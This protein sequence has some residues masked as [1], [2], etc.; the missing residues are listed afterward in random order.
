[1]PTSTKHGR[2]LGKVIAKQRRDFPINCE[3]TGTAVVNEDVQRFEAV[4]C[5]LVTSSEASVNPSAR[6]ALIVALASAHLLTLSARVL[7][8]Y[9]NPCTPLQHFL[10]R[11]IAAES[12]TIEH[13]LASLAKLVAGA[14]VVDEQVWE[15]ELLQAG[16]REGQ[17]LALEDAAPSFL[18][19]S[20]A[21]NGTA[22]EDK[23]VLLEAVRFLAGALDFRILP[24]MAGWLPHWAHKAGESF[25]RCFSG[26]MS[27]NT[28]VNRS[29]AG[30]LYRHGWGGYHPA[31][32]AKLDAHRQILSIVDL[33]R[34]VQLTDRDLLS[35]AVGSEIDDAVSH[36]EETE[37]LDRVISLRVRALGLVAQSHFLRGRW[38]R[39]TPS[40]SAGLEVFW[41]AAR[42][43]ARVGAATA[44]SGRDLECRQAAQKVYEFAASVED[45]LRGTYGHVTDAVE[46]AALCEELASEA[47]AMHKVAAAGAR[48]KNI[49]R[50]PDVAVLQEAVREAAEIV[51]SLHAGTNLENVK[52][53]ISEYWLRL[54]RVQAFT[55]NCL[56]LFLQ[57]H[58][59]DF[60]CKHAP[61]LDWASPQKDCTPLS[62]AAES[63]GGVAPI[64]LLLR[65]YPVGEGGA[66]AEWDHRDTIVEIVNFLERDHD[67]ACEEVVR[68]VCARMKAGL[69]NMNGIIQSNQPRDRAGC[70]LK[71]SEDGAPWVCYPV[72]QCN[73]H[74]ALR[75]KSGSSDPPPVHRPPPS[76]HGTAREKLLRFY[77]VHLSWIADSESAPEL[78][79]EKKKRRVVGSDEESLGGGGG[80]PVPVADEELFADSV[81]ARNVPKIFTDKV[82]CVVSPSLRDT[83]GCAVGRLTARSQLG[84]HDSGCTKTFTTA[85]P[86]LRCKKSANVEALAT[87][88]PA[89][90]RARNVR[91]GVS[92][93][94]CKKAAVPSQQCEV[95]V[96]GSKHLCRKS[97]LALDPDAFVGHLKIVAAS[98]QPRASALPPVFASIHVEIGNPTVVFLQPRNCTEYFR[99]APP[100]R[101]FTLAIPMDGKNATL[102]KSLATLT[103]HLALKTVASSL[104]G[105]TSYRVGLCSGRRLGG[106]EEGSVV[107]SSSCAARA[108]DARSWYAW[109]DTKEYV[110]AVASDAKDI[111][112]RNIVILAHRMDRIGLAFAAAAGTSLLVKLESSSGACV[113]RPFVVGLVADARSGVVSGMDPSAVARVMGYIRETM[114]SYEEDSAGG[115]GGEEASAGDVQGEDDGE[116]LLHNLHML[117]A[118][119]AA[120][121]SDATLLAL[122]TP[123]AQR[124][125]SKGADAAQEPYW[126]SSF[127][128]SLD[129]EIDERQVIAAEYATK[130]PPSQGRLHLDTVV[131]P[132]LHSDRVS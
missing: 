31:S 1:M 36:A 54:R 44:P 70:A 53:V 8:G 2:L 63:S 119:V 102:V 60:D 51:V 118:L 122:L 3:G 82:A 100:G 40:M 49:W 120:A 12:A 10:S 103:L 74:R 92:G 52:K 95:E 85:N 107:A 15:D 33:L 121:S 17:E 96:A 117:A 94:L 80:D 99:A 76:H 127:A 78:L 68:N 35:V 62:A 84:A 38:Q 73:G 77:N 64:P 69:E 45:A 39:V 6:V 130:P 124:L 88:L 86:V 48:E 110:P 66:S 24:D 57:D 58:Q 67:S 111:D 71:V 128:S 81:I 50:K 5:P 4:H 47:L 101:C 11:P 41:F 75:R 59:Y 61:V 13:H 42:E 105:L 18:R 115:A 113:L 97:S 116:E 91:C 79:E 9:L 20:R 83:K 104:A 125:L 23:R 90:S 72:V 37:S 131:Y 56:L 55:R 129:E 87:A 132:P 106:E 43:R 98:K 65:D 46:D 114:P 112:L 22:S 27:L 89:A 32:G 93:A 108:T 109:A 126:A 7:A 16:Q 26:G 28:S 29:M 25:V 34:F 19:G 14:S 21:R 123:F 30:R